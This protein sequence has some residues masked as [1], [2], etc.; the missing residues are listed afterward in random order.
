MSTVTQGVSSAEAGKADVSSYAQTPGALHFWLRRVHSLLGLAFGG[1]VCVH[2]LVNATGLGATLGFAPKMYQQN[3]DKIHQME[4]MLPIIE[5]VAIFLP[6]LFHAVY[7]S[8][9]A[10]V[11]LKLNTSSYG[12]WANIRYTIQR[13]SAWILLAFVVYHLGTLHKWGFGVFTAAHK[14]AFIAENEAYQSTVKAIQSPYANGILNAG[15][16][17]LYLLGVWS[18]AFHFANGLWTAA[19]A[20]GVTVTRASQKRWGLVCC[21]LGIGLLIVATVAWAAFAFGKGDLP[22]NATATASTEVS[23]QMNAGA[24]NTPGALQPKSQLKGPAATETK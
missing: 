18:A 17:L 6:L 3:V 5:I 20:W 12:Y 7:G 11:G 22:V 15:V 8:Y 14:P 23:E 10:S 24:T 4:P 1:Y 9:I 13:Y 21:G 16:I 19:I 2:L